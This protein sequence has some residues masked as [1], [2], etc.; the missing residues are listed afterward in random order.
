MIGMLRKSIVVGAAASLALA[1]CS[2]GSSTLAPVRQAT[3]QPAGTVAT[4]ATFSYNAALVNQS[5]LV[6]PATFP[7][8]TFDVAL[9]MKNVPGLLAYASQV[10]DPT[11]GNYRRFLTPDQIADQYAA[12]A[13]DRD[14]A[15]AYFTGHGLKVSGWRQRMLLRVSGTQANLQ[16]AFH[17]TF[18]LYQAPSGEQFI[19]P[20]TQ[21]SVD[22]GIPVVGSANIV[23]RSRQYNISLVTSRGSGSGYSPQQIAAA[24]DYNGAYAAGYTGS[25]ITVGIVGTGPVQTST[26]GRIGDAEAYKSLYGIKSASTVAIVSANSSDPVVNGNSGFASPPP[27]TAPCPNATPSD[28]AGSFSVSPT[29]ACNPEDGEAQLDTEQA[30]SLARDSKVEF[31]L[32]YNPNDGCGGANGS[33]CAAGAGD[34]YQ[35][36]YETDEELQ[37]VIDHNS[38]D[39]ISMSYGEPENGGVA[40]SGVG[41]PPYPFSSDGTGLDPTEFAMIAV[42]GI[43]AFASSGDSGANECQNFPQNGDQNLPCVSY[44]STDPNVVAVGGVTLPLNNAGQ[45]IG[46]ITAWGLQTSFGASGTG[47]GV[48]S[49]F[50]QPSYQRGLPGIIGSTRNVPDLSLEGDPVTGVALLANADPALG[51]A[52]LFPIGGTSVSSPEMAAMWALVLQACKASTSCSAKGSGAH[53]YRLGNPNATFYGI[54]GSASAYA[55]TFL[56]VTYGNN[57]LATYCYYNSGDTSNCPT[58]APGASATPLPN[59]VPIA[60]G[61]SANA[62]GGYNNLT[63]IGVPF[64]RA[65]IRSVVGV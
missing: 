48:S 36:L 20:M 42:E 35:G 33:A 61:Y 12:S 23:R 30:A 45:Q 17:T 53:P 25:G 18:G 2:G 4:S 16:S 31:Y 49:F 58:P 60:S 5:K 22:A 52:S 8:M 15:S 24:F 34:A 37:T 1:S 64:A 19:A 43:A 40:P 9:T 21:P 63:G 51:G 32:A 26:G 10:S 29:A 46:P 14:K 59:P 56:P 62:A 28:G 44:P 65:L 13:S 38:A 50:T 6:H 27:V 39:V 41:S 3:S 55:K 7:G 57:A 11:S 54:Y 47:G